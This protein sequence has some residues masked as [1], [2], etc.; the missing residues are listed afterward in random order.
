MNEFSGTIP[1]A[2]PS[3]ATVR[4]DDPRSQCY[5]DRRGFVAWTGQVRLPGVAEDRLGE[6]LLGLIAG[7]EPHFLADLRGPFAI[8]ACS[9]EEDHVLLAVDRVGIEAL[10]WSDL[11]QAISFG[12]SAI[13]V[14]RCHDG[15]PVVDSQ[16]VYDFM[17]GHMV[18]SPNTAFENVSKLKPGHAITWSQG[19]RQEFRYWQPDFDRSSSVDIG[20]LQT[21]V[22]K[23]I[24][25]AIENH[26]PT[27]ASGAFLSGGLDSS[28][29]TGLLASA[30]PSAANAF[31]IGFGIKE[32]DELEFARIAADQFDCKHHIYEVVP[33]DIV[34][35][36]PRVAAAYDEPFGNS[37]AIPTLCCARLA[38]EHGMQQ[39]FA[40]D[41]GDE[42]F[43]G[44]ER[45]VRHSIFEMY[46]RIPKAVRN[47]LMD[48]LA[49]RLD[50][51]SSVLPLRKYASYVQQANIP[52]P[53]RFESWNLIYREGRQNVF[54]QEFLDQVDTDFAMNNM[55]ETW[56]ECP[57]DDLL[58][59]M[60]WY[61]WKFVLADNDLRKVSRMCHLEGIEVVYPMLDE[62]LIDL[63][64]Q[65]ASKYKIRN[66]EL[67]WFFKESIRDL[68][69]EKIISKEKHGF[70]LPFGQWLKSNSALREL[71]QGSLDS[72]KNRGIF[73]AQFV[74][75]VW[76]E[77]RTG[78]ASYYGYAIWGP[79]A[80]R[81]V[82]C[83]RIPAM[84]G[85]RTSDVDP[86]AQLATNTT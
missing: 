58:D 43:G 23:T 63:S 3:G 74:D 8:A 84:P 16:A 80:P 28:T 81:T 32:F 68:I 34:E 18:P 67:R 21:E 39:L 12:N 71:V 60:L 70:G 35:L 27:S 2:D 10:A 52:L 47:L 19:K 45:Y 29:V 31:S 37:S 14:A 73:D 1:I 72:L 5:R 44:N 42:I 55:R 64:I 79:R 22:Q 11:Q 49:R 6:T 24:S 41:G 76:D 25:R 50:P 53:D 83:S 38:R 65:V 85:C 62:D 78:H 57:S 86:A 66:R 69:P 51:E 30:A 77:H 61:D 26:R 82:G 15:M 54:S 59:R 17:L 56:D 48:P 9:F 20:G 13:A 7:R 33:D 4:T 46:Q 40:G 36:I 75:R